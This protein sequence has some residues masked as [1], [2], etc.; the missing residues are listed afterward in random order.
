MGNVLARKLLLVEGRGDA[1]IIE[2]VVPGALLIWTNSPENSNFIA[3][4][5][6]FTPQPEPLA[7]HQEFRW[8]PKARVCSRGNALGYGK[9]E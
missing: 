6:L 5:H 1:A 3:L 4:T 2:D 8:S 9:A 7:H